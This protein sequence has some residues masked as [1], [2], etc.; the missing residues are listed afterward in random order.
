MRHHIARGDTTR[1]DHFGYTALHYAARHAD[2]VAACRLLLDAGCP[3][4][5]RTA[6]GGV[7]AL[8]RAAA[9]GRAD[10]V[11]LLLERGAAGGVCDADGQ[12][13]LHRAADGGHVRVCEMLCERDDDGGWRAQRNRR[14]QRPADLVAVQR[15]REFGAVF[16]WEPDEDAAPLVVR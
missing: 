12:T 11:R 13:A 3:I 16:V 6:A 2:G 8:H 1:T 5:A 10:C 9:A 7:T 15:R 4:E 14:G